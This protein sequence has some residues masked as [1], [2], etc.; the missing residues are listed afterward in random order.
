MAAALELPR[1][2][3][4]RLAER[5]LGSLDADIAEGWI[6][7]ARDRLAAYRKK[8]EAIQRRVAAS[9]AEWKRSKDGGSAEL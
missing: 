5:L 3:R 9:L 8:E 7:E 1:I 4:T 2:E 6:I